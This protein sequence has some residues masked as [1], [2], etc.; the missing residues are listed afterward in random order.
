MADVDAQESRQ[1][2]S[3]AASIG[4]A[5]LCQRGGGF[6]GAFLAARIAG[7]AIFGQYVLAVSTV[8]MLAGYLGMGVAGTSVRYGGQFGGSSPNSTKVSRFI[9]SWALASSLATAGLMYFFSGWIVSFLSIGDYGTILRFAAPLC[10]ASLIFEVLWGSQLGARANKSLLLTGV[11]YGICMAVILP[12]SSK[13]DSPIML[14]GHASA[15]FV[16]IAVSLLYWRSHSTRP[17]I[18]V[19]SSGTSP[20]GSQMLR[21][22][23]SQ[24][25][26]TLGIGV[27]SWWVVA[28]ISRFDPSMQQVGAYGVATQIKA[29]SVFLPGLFVSQV[30]PMLANGA[31]GS[32]GRVRVLSNMLAHSGT[33]ALIAAGGILLFLPLVITAYGPRYQHA[34]TTIILL[35]ACG[36]VQMSN[37]SMFQAV[38]LY[39]TNLAVFIAGVGA[40]VLAI[41]ATVLVPRFGATGGGIAWL[42]AESASYWMCYVVVR[43][44]EGGVAITRTVIAT[45]LGIGVV[46]TAALEREWAGG[47]GWAEIVTIALIVTLAAGSFIRAILT[48]RRG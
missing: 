23:G 36:A 8:G 11:S 28:L 4:L 26:S 7:P 34:A 30:M 3:G 1:V 24:I 33:T 40:A 21:F 32:S 29:I 20:T 37:G 43:K 2:F 47:S 35:V 5:Q 41:S 19:A 25:A 6:L 31:T 48:A 15:V 42:V 13:F 10:I 22:G 17:D 18:A 12:I 45:W 16:S 14:L 39:R 9:W 44:L 38:M 27:A 46:T